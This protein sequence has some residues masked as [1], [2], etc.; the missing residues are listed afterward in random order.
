MRLAPS[1]TTVDWNV[2][3]PPSRVRSTGGGQTTAPCPPLLISAPL[4]L[5]E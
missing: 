3:V 5:I 2:R 1:R 4:A